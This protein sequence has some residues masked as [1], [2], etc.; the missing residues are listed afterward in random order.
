MSRNVPS[1]SSARSGAAI[2]RAISTI[3]APTKDYLLRLGLERFDTPRD[4]FDH[5]TRRHLL[6]Q[7]EH[8]ANS[9]GEFQRG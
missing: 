3:I 8:Y 5:A 4:L 9:F 7:F 1:A 2:N 6:V